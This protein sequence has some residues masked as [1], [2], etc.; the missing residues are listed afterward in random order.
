MDRSACVDK[1]PDTLINSSVTGFF[2]SAIFSA[3]APIGDYTYPAIMV[4]SWWRGFFYALNELAMSIASGLLG[5]IGA[6]VK[7]KGED[8]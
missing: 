5:Y 1:N 7:P 6:N 3:I 4:A 8:K 2:F